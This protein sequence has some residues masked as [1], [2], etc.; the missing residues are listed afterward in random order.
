MSIAR[1]VFRLKSRPRVPLDVRHLR[2]DDFIGMRLDDILKL[3]AWEGCRKITLGDLFDV[4]EAPKEA[5]KDVKLIEIEVLGDLTKK[6]WYLGYKMTGGRII[7]RGDGGHLVGYKMSG[8]SIV[9]YGNVG[10]WLGAKM[11]GGEIEVHGNAGSFVGA[12]LLGE[13]PGRGMRGGTIAVHGSAGS[14]IG[15]GMGGGTII[16][17][18][19]AGDGIGVDMAGGTII[20]QNNAGLH[21]GI[22]MSGGRVV[23]GGRIGNIMPSF[24]IDSIVPEVRVRGRMFRK[25]FALF[26]GD[27]IVGGRGSILIAYEENRELIEPLAKLLS[28]EI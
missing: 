4:I 27:V 16:I 2:P 10:N 25:Q 23:V 5:P 15:F 8:G 24:Y 19:N 13:K 20:I 7:V 1:F 26:I 6:F 28:G 17:N 18:N 9:V 21:H 12:K 22:G 14:F 11:R 3:R